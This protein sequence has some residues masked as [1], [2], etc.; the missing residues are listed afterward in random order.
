MQFEETKVYPAIRH[1]LGVRDEI[2][3]AVSE[4]AEAMNLLSR[5]PRLVQDGDWKQAVQNCHE[6]LKSEVAA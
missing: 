1:A 3:D 6:E 4:H 5:L 2:R